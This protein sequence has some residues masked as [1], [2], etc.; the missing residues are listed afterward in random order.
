[1]CSKIANI[2]DRFTS[3][4]PVPSVQCSRY[5]VTYLAACLPASKE[6]R[7]RKHFSDP[8]AVKKKNTEQG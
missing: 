2:L 8:G 5:Y 6:N 1:M 3:S 7:G 4:V